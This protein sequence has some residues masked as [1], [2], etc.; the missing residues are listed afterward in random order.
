[1]M[2]RGFKTSELYWTIAGE[3]S[4]VIAFLQDKI[5]LGLTLI[6]I[7]SIQAAFNLSR[8]MTKSL[9]TAS[10]VQILPM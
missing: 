1:M 9:P 8:G 6:C 4:L 2:Y 3:S 7:I 10:P 5:S